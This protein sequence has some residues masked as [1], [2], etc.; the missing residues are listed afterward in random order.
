MNLFVFLTKIFE[1]IVNIY[2]FMDLYTIGKLMVF[3]FN[4]WKR[5]PHGK[6]QNHP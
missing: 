6:T 2:F 3:F 1:D 5:V 4:R